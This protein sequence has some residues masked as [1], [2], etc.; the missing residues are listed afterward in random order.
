[1]LAI[2]HRCSFHFSLFVVLAAGLAASLAACSGVAQQAGSRHETQFAADWSEHAKPLLFHGM[3]RDP[4]F[5]FWQ[6]PNILPRGT[7]RVIEREHG[8]A[9]D[10]AEL[11]DGYRFEVNGPEAD[12]YLNIGSNYSNLEA[13]DEKYIRPGS[14]SIN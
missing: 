4:G 8:P 5:T 14:G 6:V 13:L 2:S 10:T 11:V 12:I 9:G 3:S 7:Y 1:M